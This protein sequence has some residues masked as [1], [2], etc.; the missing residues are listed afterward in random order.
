MKLYDLRP[1]SKKSY[2]FCNFGSFIL[3]ILMENIKLHF[4][5]IIWRVI[6]FIHMLKWYESGHDIP[7]LLVEAYFY[8]SFITKLLYKRNSTEKA[9]IRIK[10]INDEIRKSL[11]IYF[12]IRN[13]ITK[14][15]NV[16]YLTFKGYTWNIVF[17]CF[18]LH[19]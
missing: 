8:Y 16:S 11:I 15:Y 1:Q 2:P 9:Y 14:C 13:N 19:F 7:H 4:Y 3:F 5:V 12:I 10:T 18:I 6:F 17:L